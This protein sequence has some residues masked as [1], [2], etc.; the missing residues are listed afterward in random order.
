MDQLNLTH[1][2]ST[3]VSNR[4]VALFDRHRANLIQTTDRLFAGLLAFEWLVMVGTAL[5]IAPRAWAGTTSWIHPHVWAATILG[6]VIVSLPIGLAI[7]QPGKV[8]TRHVIAISQMLTGTLLIHLS[9]GRIETHFH[10]FGSLAFLAFYRDWSVLISATIVVAL[11]HLIRGIFC[12]QSVYGVSFVEPWRW[13]EHA[14][15][16]AFEDIFLIWSCRRSIWEMRAMA[17]REA[18][19]EDLHGQVEQQ[20]E[21]RTAELRRSEARKAGILEGAL[22]AIVRADHTGRIIEFNPAAESVFGYTRDDVVGKPLVELIVPPSLRAAHCLGMERFLSTGEDAVLGKRIETNALRADGTEF[23]VELAVCV[24]RQAN[25]PIFSAYLRDLSE[26]KAVEAALAER[27]RLADLTSA[28]AEALTR[29]DSAGRIFEDCAKAVALH[30]DAAWAGIWTLN[31][32]EQRLELRAR[33]GMRG[34]SDGPIPQVGVGEGEIG[35]IARERRPCL[36]SDLA[37]IPGQGDQERAANP[38]IVAFAGHP[39]VVDD[40]LI[41]VMAVY[42]RKPLS[43]ATQNTLAAAADSIALGIARL[44]CQQEQEKARLTAEAASRAKSEFLA[45]MSHEIRT[46]MNGILGMTELA[47]E[48]P[49][50]RRQREFL[51][52]AKSSADSLLHIINDILDFS[53]IEAGKLDVHPEPFDLRN[54]VEGTLRTLALRADAKGLELAC[55]IASDVPIGHLKPVGTNIGGGNLGRLGSRPRQYFFLQYP[56]RSSQ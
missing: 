25:P 55:Q 3:A 7:A 28:V 43:A 36:T 48:T 33:A 23:P 34:D 8:I 15:W 30:L 32:T 45:N 18:A 53:K 42:G 40:R 12:P 24:I 13:V 51:T 2:S 35:M 16:V 50:S 26:R 44:Q 46:P 39:L 9:G 49:L 14:G 54:C 10:I 56:T 37:G 31:E 22:D 19:L 38:E 29:S 4:A 11:D 27:A 47:L 6:G 20:V 17:G 21:A 41:G 52:M 1:E 5:V